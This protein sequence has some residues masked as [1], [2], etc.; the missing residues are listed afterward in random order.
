MLNPNPDKPVPKRVG[1]SGYGVLLRTMRDSLD[2]GYHCSVSVIVVLHL[3]V[4]F[5]Y[6]A[7]GEPKVVIR[8]KPK[9]CRD[10]FLPEL[11]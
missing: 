3:A 7:H 8:G 1:L 11:I 10:F 6:V 4:L 2:V 5:H 9:I